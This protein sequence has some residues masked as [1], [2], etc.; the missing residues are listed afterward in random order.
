MSELK[1]HVAA[2]MIA[3]GENLF[4]DPVIEIGSF[5]RLQLRYNR[6]NAA[7]VYEVMDKA[8]LM[9]ADGYSNAEILVTQLG[10]AL[11]A[12]GLDSLDGLLRMFDAAYPDT[13]PREESP[14]CAD[15]G[16]SAGDG[17]HSRECSF[18]SRPKRRSA[19]NGGKAH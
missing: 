15:C 1:P 8:R 14:P 17:I 16:A 12:R 11:T 6:P 9:D 19:R 13:A 7:T 18:G 5:G 10:E 4:A 3:A 2:R